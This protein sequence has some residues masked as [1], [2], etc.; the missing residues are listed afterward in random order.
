VA[1]SQILLKTSADKTHAS[2]LGEY[3]N[4]HVMGGYAL[5]FSSM[6]LNIVA[7]RWVELKAGPVFGSASYVFALVLGALILRERVT[8][9]LLWGNVLIILGIIVFNL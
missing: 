8:P 3:L 1:I 5:L 7:Y 2:R 4:W 6:L 9:G